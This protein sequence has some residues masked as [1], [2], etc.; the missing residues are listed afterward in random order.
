MK[1]VNNSLR[2]LTSLE[3][4]K[5]LGNQRIFYLIS[6]FYNI[7]KGSLGES[8]PPSVAGLLLAVVLCGLQNPLRTMGAPHRHTGSTR[9]HVFDVSPS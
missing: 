3:I 7:S 8:E 2:V 5:C 4:S 6:L 9:S 1:V